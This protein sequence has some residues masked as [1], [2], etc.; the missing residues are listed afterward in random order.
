MKNSL[1]RAASLIMLI[2]IPAVV[3]AS[4]GDNVKSAR[5]IISLLN[6]GKYKEVMSLFDSTMKK[7]APESRL[8]DVW[9]S[10]IKDSGNLEAQLQDTTFEVKGYDIVIVTCKFARSY[11][12]IR[13]VFDK[14]GEVAGLFFSPHKDASQQSGTTQNMKDHGQSEIHGATYISRD[15]TFENEDAHIK[16]AG[17]LT[18]PDSIGRFPAVLLIPGSGPMDRDETVMGH[19]IFLV[20]ADYLTRN[21]I[22]VLRVD[23]RGIGES[24]G[25]FQTA[26][27]KDFASDAMAGVRYLESLSEI[28]HNEIGLIGHSE[29]GIIAPM[30]ADESHHVA[31]MVL[32]G[33]PGLPGERILTSQGA[34][35]MKA[36]GAPD[37]IIE[38]NRSLQQQLFAVVKT[39]KDSAKAEQRL[40][41]ILEDGLVRLGMVSAAQREEASAFINGQLNFLLSP[42]MKSFLT[43]DPRPALE[44][45]KCPVLALWGSKDLQVPPSENLPA[46]ED[47]L[48]KGGDEDIKTMELDG[49][50]HLFQDAKTGSPTEYAAIQETFSPKALSIIADWI[51]EKTRPAR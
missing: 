13:L 39:E 16:L 48:K 28:K 45:V 11:Q 36:N 47:A 40:R 1:L 26:T 18:L 42:W 33:A 10:L 3:S 27:L 37:S 19:K 4:G 31:F 23:D 12:D 24:T 17:T 22:A 25:N 21:G 34:L 7:A 15:V 46:V 20:L 50:N 30:V 8:R 51:A 29:G 9:V 41:K 43:Y 2:F 44:K 35:I 49:L 32:L 14:S 6:E 5:K 38:I